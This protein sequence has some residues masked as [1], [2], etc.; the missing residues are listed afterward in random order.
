MLYEV[1]TDLDGNSRILNA[2]VD[3]GAYEYAAQLY[4]MDATIGS[5]YQIAPSYNFV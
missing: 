5:G 2:L 3:A 4:Q 1:I